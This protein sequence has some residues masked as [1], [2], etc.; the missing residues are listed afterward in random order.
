MSVQRPIRATEVAIIEVVN[1]T[2]MR[3][4][5]T[6]A[7]PSLLIHYPSL[8]GGMLV[9]SDSILQSPDSYQ[10]VDPGAADRYF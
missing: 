4:E 8:K 1:A 9:C 3:G 10:P 5:R 2:A 7:A 6:A